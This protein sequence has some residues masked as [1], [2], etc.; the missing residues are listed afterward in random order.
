MKRLFLLSLSVF[1]LTFGRYYL[2]DKRAPQ[3]PREERRE[4]RREELRVKSLES[5][6]QNPL[7][8]PIDV[9]VRDVD[10]VYLL[11][12]LSSEAGIPISLRDMPDRPKVNYFSMR[13]PLRVILD[14]LASANDLWW[15]LD[16]NGV[17]LYRHRN[18]VYKM[19]LPLLKKEIREDNQLARLSFTMDKSYWAKVEDSLRSLISDRGSKV[20][21]N[22]MGYVFVYARPSEVRAIENAVRKMQEDASLEVPL[23]VKVM[24]LDEDIFREIGIGLSARGSAFDLRSNPPI[25][26]APFLTLSVLSS[27]VEARLRALAQSGKVNV[28]E[29]NRITALNGQPIVYAPQKTTRIINSY[30]V[31]FIGS[32]GQPVPVLDVKTEDVPEGS[33]LLIVPQ[34]VDKNKILFD[35][36]YKL[37]KI[38]NI[39]QTNVT[40]MPNTQ[41][42]VVSLPQM[43]THS[44]LAQTIL[45]KGRSVALFSNSLSREEITRSGIPFL[46]DIPILGHLFGTQGKKSENVRLLIVITFLN[47]IN[48]D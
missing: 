31:A 11:S 33:Y 28:I 22:E 32:Q 34:Y 1:T 5:K 23:E 47:E 4:E 48:P 24:L 36:Y 14:E 39:R 38:D 20:S 40:L 15:E 6:P 10:L 25:S 29:T 7:D 19:T 27:V 3:Q 37:S 42:N 21:V 2:P 45:E 12:M 43:T 8:T 26:S 18:A 17:L 35:F 46:K 9:N 30:K 44:N 16:G 41:P 13:K